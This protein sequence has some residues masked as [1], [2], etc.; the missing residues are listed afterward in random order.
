MNFAINI[1]ILCFEVIYYSL[2][3]KFAKNQGKLWKYVLLFTLISIL[4]FFVGTN[5]IYSYLV[6]V[7]IVLYGIIYL[8]KVKCT[9]YDMM[10]IFIMLIFKHIIEIPF[11]LL[12]LLFIK[13]IY[14]ITMLVGL[15]KIAIILGLKNKIKAFYNKCQKIWNQNNFYIRYGFIVFMLTYTIVSCLYCIVKWL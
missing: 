4:F 6:L 13:N 1:I 8:V 2:F 12:L 7:L 14:V 3:M 15:V 5:H 10:I 11:S 9:L